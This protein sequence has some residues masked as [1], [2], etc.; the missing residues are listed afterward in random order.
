MGPRRFLR[1]PTKISR[2]QINACLRL[3]RV[4]PTWASGPQWNNTVVLGRSLWPPRV[5][6]GVCFCWGAG[7]ARWFTLTCIVLCSMSGAQVGSVSLIYHD[8]CKH[9]KSQARTVRRPAEHTVSRS[10]SLAGARP[11][12]TSLLAISRGDSWIRAYLSPPCPSDS[13]G[14]QPSLNVRGKNP[15]LVA[16]KKALD[17]CHNTGADS[18]L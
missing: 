6:S 8:K 1:G 18:F 11:S 2:C 17:K 4:I 13:K 14:L 15:P 3:T 5:S 7:I 10:S 9:V 16:A 12:C